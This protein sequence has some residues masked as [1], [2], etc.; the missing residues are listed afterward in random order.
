M[1]WGR[2]SSVKHRKPGSSSSQFTS[3]TEGKSSNINQKKKARMIGNPLASHMVFSLWE[4]VWQAERWLLVVVA[5]F[6]RAR[7]LGEC[8]TIRSSL[9]PFP[10]LFYRVEISSR[11]LI[12]L[13][14][15]GSVHSGSAS[16]DDCYRVF[17]H[18]LDSG[19][20]SPLW[21][22]W[23]KGVCRIYCLL[24]SMTA[25]LILVLGVRCV[26]KAG[27]T[28]IWRHNENASNQEHV[29]QQKTKTTTK[30]ELIDTAVSPIEDIFDLQQDDQC[31]QRK[32]GQGSSF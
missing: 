5:F 7:I 21:L 20:V 13:F 3:T 30:D 19:I 32:S 14:R 23:V 11:K 1:N 6:L 24:Q 22:Q 17:P 16:W 31:L 12:P 10:S 8:L 26:W 9:V 2:S 25:C 29:T 4:D 27:W 28:I 18:C 15:P